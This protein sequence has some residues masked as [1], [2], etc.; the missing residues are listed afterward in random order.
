MQLVSIRVKMEKAL[1]NCKGLEGIMKMAL[2]LLLQESTFR[3]TIIR[4]LRELLELVQGRGFEILLK[5]EYLILQFLIKKLGKH[6]L[7]LST[8]A[9]LL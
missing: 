3:V 1:Q 4:G 5:N 9:L 7:M 6:L 2:P 8:P